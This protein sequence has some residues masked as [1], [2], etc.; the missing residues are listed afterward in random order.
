VKKVKAE[1]PLQLV[2][3]ELLQSKDSGKDLEARIKRFPDFDDNAPR[4]G[5]SGLALALLLAGDDKHPYLEEIP[6]DF[7]TKEDTLVSAQGHQAIDVHPHLSTLKQFLKLKKDG[8]LTLTIELDEVYD[9]RNSRV[10]RLGV[11]G[12][13]NHQLTLLLCN[14]KLQIIQ[15]CYK[16]YSA[17]RYMENNPPEKAFFYDSPIKFYDTFVRLLTRLVQEKEKGDGNNNNKPDADDSYLSSRLCSCSMR[18]SSST[19][20]DGEQEHE[21]FPSTEANECSN[22]LFGTNLDIGNTPVQT[23]FTIHITAMEHKNFNYELTDSLPF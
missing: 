15:S 1:K 3:K 16:E 17:L 10:R 5:G 12:C 4:C 9:K 23:P 13:Y 11:L 2:I 6:D 8:F 7:W 14:K 20:K 19:T 21:P 22:A 18:C